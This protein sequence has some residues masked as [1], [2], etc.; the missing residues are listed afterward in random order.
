MCRLQVLKREIFGPIIP[1]LAV[2]SVEEAV[3]TALASG[4]N[5]L[6]IVSWMIFDVWIRPLESLTALGLNL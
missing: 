5:R 4:F 3:K 2:A 6:T 1:I